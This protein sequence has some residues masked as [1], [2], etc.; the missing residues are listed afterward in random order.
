MKDV[1]S[2]EWVEILKK[3]KLFSKLWN[4]YRRVTAFSFHSIWIVGKIEFKGIERGDY[5]E[6][7]FDFENVK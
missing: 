2:V 5:F 4:L 1:S 7:S 6:Q 3:V